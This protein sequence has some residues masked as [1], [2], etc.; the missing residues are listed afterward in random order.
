V[1]VIEV[2]LSVYVKLPYWPADTEFTIQHKATKIANLPRN[3]IV[4]MVLVVCL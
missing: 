4:V 3:F 2:P 1:I